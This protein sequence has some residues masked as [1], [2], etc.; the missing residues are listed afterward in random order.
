[1]KTKYKAGQTF[2]KLTI[3]EWDKEKK[4]YLCQC[5]CGNTTYARGN[6][7]AIGKHTQCRDC[8]NKNRKKN[9]MTGYKRMRRNYIKSAQRRGHIFDLS[10]DTF[11][12]LTQQNCHYCGETPEDKTY[13]HWTFKANGIDRVDNNVGY[14]EDNCV[15]C[16]T[17]CNMAKRD[18]NVDEFF[19]WIKS[20]YEKR[21]ND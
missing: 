4:S 5:Q 15:S 16:C 3:I 9:P 6:A 18:L 8:S 17:H 11:Y 19:K 7:M 20:V 21:F 1:M 10:F 12:K 13:E 2:G 14:L